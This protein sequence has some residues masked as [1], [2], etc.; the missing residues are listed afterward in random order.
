MVCGKNEM[1][2]LRK[3]KKAM[4]RATCGVK[5]IER[6]SSQ[7]V[8]DFVGLVEILDRLSWATGVRWYGHVLLEDS[9]NV[10]RRA[11]DFEVVG[12]RG[13]GRPKMTWRR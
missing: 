7:E 11:F 1:V 4:M 13:H 6:R 2:F 5:L 10:L 8:M 12:R 3:I 9:D